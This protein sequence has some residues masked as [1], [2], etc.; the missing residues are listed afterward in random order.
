M[1]DAAARS[2][3]GEILDQQ[4]PTTPTTTP[5]SGQTVP[6][7]STTTPAP[8]APAAETKPTPSPTDAP[9]VPDKYEFK[10]PD[11]YTLDPTAYEAAIPVFKELGLTNDQAQKL[12]DIQVQREIALAK[13]PEAT[14]N[15]MRKDWQGKTLSDP[16]IKAT[17][18]K[19]SGKTGIDAV[20]INLARTLAVLPVD[21]Q[22][23]FKDAMNL[24]GAGDHPA[25]IKAFNRLAA[26]VTEGSHVAGK[27]PS[28]EG[29]IK[30]GTNVKPSPAQALYPN[31]P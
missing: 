22:V 10:A 24:T 31:N 4:I 7:L 23:E 13:A 30:P 9:S 18:D 8:D 1:N 27:G 20:K 17:I 5:L 21:L 26:Y 25:F 28:V 6:D 29:Q 12:I 2:P 14:M 15:A 16:E 3:T 11:N 19:N